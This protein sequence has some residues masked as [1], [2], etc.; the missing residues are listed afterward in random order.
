MASTPS[1]QSYPADWLTDTETMAWSME[2][3]GCYRQL[4][5]YLWL[6]EGRLKFS[7]ESLKVIWR[8]RTRSQ[9]LS[10][11][12]EIKSKFT[13]VDIDGV[14]YITNK[15]VDKEMQKQS[16]HRLSKS[17]AG[18][19]GME[20]RYGKPNRAITEEKPVPNSSSSSSSSSSLKDNI[21]GSSATDPTPQSLRNRCATV[22]LKK[23]APTPTPTPKPIPKP[24]TSRFVPPTTDQVEAYSQSIAYNTLDTDY[25]LNYYKTRGWTLG[26]GQPMRDWKAAIRTWKY[27]ERKQE[28][29]NNDNDNN[30]RDLRISTASKFGSTIKV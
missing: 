29:K 5:D 13:L 12:I 23:T 15:R 14:E 4:V 3:M 24:K 21:R 27:R 26:R 22:A 7:Q 11:W 10:R 2:Q 1:Y 17:L 16:E 8:H 6:A 20:S 30:R 9:S 18:K 19:K 28:G 25:F